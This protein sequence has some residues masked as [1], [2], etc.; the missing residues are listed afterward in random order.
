MKKTLDK[1]KQDLLSK[2]DEIEEL[3]I[4]FKTLEKEKEQIAVSNIELKED[5]LK[6]KNTIDKLQTDLNRASDKE[7]EL[8]LKMRNLEEINSRDTENINLLKQA[9]ALLQNE[10]L[11]LEND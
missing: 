8:E 3:C 5:I 10:K 4:K 7:V 6:D 11:S 1:A 9:K 2:D